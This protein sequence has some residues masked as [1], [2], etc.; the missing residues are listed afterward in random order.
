MSWGDRPLPRSHRRRK[1][2]GRGGLGAGGR[3][4][5]RGHCAWGFRRVPWSLPAARC[6]LTGVRSGRA[7]CGALGAISSLSLTLLRGTA[8]S[9]ST[10]ALTAQP[11]LWEGP[12]CRAGRA[13]LS[14]CCVW[15]PPSS[16]DLA[17]CSQGHSPPLC[18]GGRGGF[19]PLHAL[20]EMRV[21]STMC[22]L[23]WSRRP[24]GL[25]PA[26]PPA[27]PQGAHL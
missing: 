26:C 4:R 13:P 15:G 10:A 7:D 1:L 24:P 6:V 21:R 14:L 9:T 27:Q 3:D 8:P 2:C 25:A 16:T 11:V 22:W 19:A 12:V 20:M 18:S 5:D 17:L 23:D